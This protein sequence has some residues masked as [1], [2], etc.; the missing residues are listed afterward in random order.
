MIGQNVFGNASDILVWQSE[1]TYRGTW[2]ILS[3][4]LITLGLCLWTAL[5]LNI[6]QYKK[7]SSQKWR[8]V[9]WL[10]WGALAPELVSTTAR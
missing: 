6:A 10:V 9:G 1:P 8:K 3:S 7:E 5:H 4:C 2:N